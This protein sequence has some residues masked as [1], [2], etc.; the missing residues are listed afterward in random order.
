MT[1]C[2][3]LNGASSSGKSSISREL[4][5]LIPSLLHIQIDN[6]AELYFNMFADNYPHKGEWCEERYIR[7]IAIREIL[8]NTATIMLK[9]SFYVCIDTGWDGPKAD[10]HMN[11]YLDSLKDFQPLIIG[12]E[13]K[14]EELERREKIRGDRKIGLARAQLKEG[15]HANRPYD[16]IVDNM[17]RSAKENAALIDNIRRN[18]SHKP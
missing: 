15:I 1:K 9:Q 8:I 7:Q 16:L 18:K 4:Q 13:C 5:K 12:V 17:T 2:I 3:I 10:E 11:Y 6:I 14:L